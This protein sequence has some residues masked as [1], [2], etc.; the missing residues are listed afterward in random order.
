MLGRQDFVSCIVENLKDKGFQHKRIKELEDEFKQRASVYEQSGRDSTT[1]STL[2]MSDMFDNLATNTRERV[3]RTAA[4][5]AAQARNNAR[6]AEALDITTSGFVMDGKP[7]SKGTALARAAVSTVEHDPRFTGGSYSGTR[8]TVRGQMFALF[9]D[10]LTKL[11]KGAFGRQR[12]KMHLDNVIREVKGENTGDALAKKFAD[13]WLRVQDLGVD[14]FNQ[15]GGS[16]RRLDRYL[17][18]SQNGVKVSKA[19]REAWVKTHMDTVDWSKTTWPD[20]TQIPVEDR[21]K[22]LNNV[23]E[24]LSTD[25]A[26]KIDA[27]AFRGKGRA[28]GNQLDQ[29]RFLHYKDAAAWLRVHQEFGDGNVFE[30]FVRHIDDMAHKIALVETY[31]PSPEMTKMNL[32][33]IVRKNAAKLSAKDVAD[34][35]AVLKN[36][37]DPMFETIMRQNPMDPNSVMGNLVT[38]TSNILTSA[39]L[40]SA[41]FLAIPGDFMQTASVRAL[42]NMGM[43]DGVDTYLK[44]IA[45]DTEFM[46]DISTQ[47]GFVMDEVVMSTYAQERFTGLATQGPA[48]TRMISEAVM[49]ASL[50][51]PHTRS[52]RW[53]V[54]MEFMGLMNRMKN[55]SFDELPFKHVLHRYG[56]TP[57]E[58]NVLRKQKSWNPRQ[59]VNILRPIDLM[60]TDIPNK[61][62]LYRKLQGMI[63]EEAR[64]MVPEATIEGATTLRGTTRPDTLVGAL[65]YSFSMY[66]NFP[67]SFAMIY[68]RLGLTAPDVKSRVQFYAGLG[69]S[70]T[71]VGA[72]GTQMR[73]ISKGRDP[74]PMDNAA[75][76]GKSFLSGGALSIWG[77]FLFAGINEHGNGPADM[78]GGPVVGLLGDTTNLVFGDVFQWAGT[79]GSLNDQEFKSSTASRATEYASRYAPGTSVWWARLVLQRQVFDRLRQIADPQAYK[80]HKAK[81]KRQKTKYGNDFWWAPGQEAPDRA[82]GLGG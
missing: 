64:T 15:A 42:N 5:I 69:A 59:D 34:A 66:K 45:T 72:L 4:M 24:T 13:G 3:K 53:A 28:L 50:L 9:G 47:S 62:G 10:S 17:P 8:E 81:V 21:I 55:K 79:L 26:A 48:K 31:G 20:G 39:Q 56:V 2:A 32:E 1:A 65:M 74:L 60:D 51:S 57:D 12:G 19:G 23:F 14:M 30:T 27:S 11:G 75:F 67:V 35:E 49:R 22:V 36:K 29:H 63:V 16:M 78:V 58:W 46:K 43:F 70:M 73:E 18:Q 77:D 82:P 41:A 80:K 7:G 44:T 61:Q 71:L 76:L 68:G 37:F 25:G 52:A 6:V 38:G 40:G 33:A 54:S